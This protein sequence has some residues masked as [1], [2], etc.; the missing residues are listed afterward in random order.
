M[1]PALR[2]LYHRLPPP[3]ASAAA[4]LRGWQLRRWR[5]GP[6][7][8]RFI[9]GAHAREHWPAARWQAYQEERL[10][11]IL[12]RAERH[13]PYYRAYW[14]ERRRAGDRTP[15]DVLANWPILEKETLRRD[16]LA[17][18]AEDCDPR[19]MVHEH[20]SGTTGKSLDLYWSVSTTRAWYALLEARSRYWHGAKLGEPWGI[21]AGQ[22]VTPPSRTRPPFW[23]WNAALQQLYMSVYHL[24]PDHMPAYL[25]E[26]ARRGV[27]WMIGYPSS[28][29][30]LAQTALRIGWKNPC[31]HTINTYGEQ[32][33]PYQRETIAR[34]F[35]CAVVQTY[36]LAELNIAASECPHGRLHLFPEV[37]IA[38]IVD[39]H[40]AAVPDG[41]P[42][43]L[44]ATGLFNPDNP[45]IRYD[46]GDG[47]AFPAAPTPCACGRTL[48]YLERLDGRVEDVVYLRDGR[49]LGRLDGI[50]KERLPVT[51]A[52]IVQDS[53]DRIRVRIVP[54][55]DYTPAA[56]EAIR[57]GVLA[58]T[59]PGVEVVIE[60][61][62]HIAHERNGKFRL[63][64]S[65]LSA[66]ERARA[67]AD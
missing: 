17:F 37:G 67:R 23:V 59:G 14:A 66:Q 65:H 8:Q 4:T 51:A 22:I 13:V 21:V 18:V 15:R 36:G 47:A 38:E 35:G 6:D 11:F 26:I 58:R 9:A 45:L 3:L 27:G 44:L 19:R 50:F 46:T 12:H 57:E 25:A 2:A 60:P 55:A 53:L 28:Y 31:V 40:G 24:S 54:A 10:A 7:T 62:E 61:C 39:R 49:A 29:Y 32:L 52:Q 63:V 34:A 16:P 1:N 33:F 48:P 5:Y 41:Q 43:R 64:V 56:A 42:G 20:T 30:A